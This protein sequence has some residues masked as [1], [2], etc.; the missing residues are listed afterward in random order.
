[1]E[2]KDQDKDKLNKVF[3]AYKEVQMLKLEERIVGEEALKDF[4]NNWKDNQVPALQRKVVTVQLENLHQG[5][6]DPAFLSLTEALAEIKLSTFSLLDVGCATGYYAE[7]IK[8]LDKRSIDYE[9]CDYSEDMIRAAKGY[10]PNEK[11]ETQDVTCLS[12]HNNAFDVVLISGVL[13]HVP[14]Y[15]KGITEVCRIAKQYII[16]H[17]C[18]LTSKFENVHTI[19]SQYNIEVPRIYFSKKKIMDE[20]QQRGFCLIKEIDTYGLKITF[21]AFPSKL[22]RFIKKVI[23]RQ[24]LYPRA[25]KTLVF[26]ST[27]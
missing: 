24:S 26:E 14:D 21:R 6:I 1:M 7:V 4:H 23:R 18:P 17:R 5:I 20:I 3:K 16:W 10:Y 19:A 13:E 12:Y 22:R 2:I 27:D 25:T 15:H 11:F 8:T 9:G